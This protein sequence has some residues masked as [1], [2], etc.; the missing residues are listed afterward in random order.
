MLLSDKGDNSLH[1]FHPAL[2][3]SLAVPIFGFLGT[4]LFVIDVCQKKGGSK[5]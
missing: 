5:T 3:F 2:S 4:L 1:F